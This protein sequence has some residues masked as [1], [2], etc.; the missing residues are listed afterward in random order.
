MKI[1]SIDAFLGIKGGLND[2]QRDVYFVRTL[3]NL[4]NMDSEIAK[5][6][7]KMASVIEG[8]HGKKETDIINSDKFFYNRVSKLRA[9]SD[10]EDAVFYQKQYTN[11][12][13][14]RRAVIKNNAQ[15]EEFIQILNTAC[16]KV[17]GLYKKVKQSVNESMEKN[18]IVKMLFWSDFV[19]GKGFADWNEK[20]SYKIIADNVFKEQEYLF[21]YMLTLLGCDV[22]LMERSGDIDTVDFLKE[23]SVSFRIGEY[24][25]VKI[26][27]FDYSMLKQDIDVERRSGNNLSDSGMKNIHAAKEQIEK[28]EQSKRVKI[29]HEKFRRAD[30]EKNSNK[31]INENSNV[32]SDNNNESK[33]IIKNEQDFERREKSFEELAL[34]AKS[35]VMIAVH[36]DEGEVFS[37]GSGIM[38]GT[39]GYILTNCHVIAGG[40]FFSVRMEEDENVYRTDVVVKSNNILDLAIIKI[41]RILLPIPI[42]F[43]KKELVRGQKVVAIGSP[44]GLF[45]SVSDGIISGFRK[46]D[47]VDMIQFTAPISHGSSG[48]ALLNMFGEV[49]GISTAGFD[50]G[51][52]LNLAVHFR[53]INMFV[54][55]F[56]R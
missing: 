51:Q 55:G 36:N 44:L 11:F 10:Y 34:L 29:S 42:Y 6:D 35:V 20:K 27:E 38:I 19:V 41:D 12:K 47:S 18:F 28:T 30:R 21:Y 45:N 13:E 16:E 40:R 43:G 56:I 48:G 23:L 31:N 17:L 46:V 14:K 54:N 33:K 37:T 52:N 9:I 26:P 1:N 32:N 22:L 4:K 3:G 5:V 24:S 53:D 2:L 50:D 39:G 7:K 8:I 49:I 15:D 25:E